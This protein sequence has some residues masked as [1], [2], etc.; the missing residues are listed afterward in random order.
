MRFAFTDDQLALRDAVRDL[1][2][3]ECTPDQLR[4][5]WRA[6][7]GRIPGLWAKLAEMGVTALTAP[8]EFGGLGM[9]EL[10]LVL[11]LEETGRAALPE[12]IVEH[13][14]VALPLLLDADE[15]TFGARLLDG[16]VPYA[17]SCDAY[18]LARDGELHL[19]ER[20]IVALEPHQSVDGARRL[21]GFDW[22]ASEATRIGGGEEY[23][24]GLDRGALGV[25]AQLCG[26]ADRMIAM[27]VDYVKERKQ[28]GVPIGSFQAVKHH[29]ANARMQL[30]F[31][32]PLVYRAAYSAANDDA[33]RS[34]HVSM[35]KASASDAAEL[36]GRVAL[37]CHGAIAYT[38][39]Y[40]L[41]L[42]LK[43]TWALARAWGDAAWHRARVANVVL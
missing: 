42:Y 41:H 6:E 4:V 34:T 10:D 15:R 25:A 40:D 26:L 39:E 20:E 12:P 33:A 14:A 9:N 8:E 21:F 32:R 11:I 38:V 1:L 5:A 24:L 3:K 18:V 23:G 19:V 37:Q 36:A 35:A 16:F 22:T 13:V 2:D 7:T 28:F 27:T 29:L 43:R 17:N 30:E 31:A